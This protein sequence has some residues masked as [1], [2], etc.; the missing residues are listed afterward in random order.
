MAKGGQWHE[1]DKE[2]QDKTAGIYLENMRVLNGSGIGYDDKGTTKEIRD[3]RFT[4]ILYPYFGTWVIKLADGSTDSGSSF[5]GFLQ[6][7]R[8]YR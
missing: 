5:R 4:A 1:R 7:F 8:R 2:N 6:A 3:P